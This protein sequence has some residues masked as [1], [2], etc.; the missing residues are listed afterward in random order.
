MEA[1]GRRKSSGARRRRGRKLNSDSSMDMASIPEERFSP[2]TR[3]ES[4]Q[5]DAYISYRDRLVSIFY[6]AML[7]VI[8]EKWVSLKDQDIVC[9]C[10]GGLGPSEQSHEVLVTSMPI[11]LFLYR[12]I[13]FFCG[14]AQTSFKYIH[15]QLFSHPMQHTP[16]AKTTLKF[17]LPIP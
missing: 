7:D 4:V 5:E 10:M 6:K 3:L 11:Q 16:K 14:N 12:H 13:I 15:Q 17:H 2:T 9:S 1:S 8:V